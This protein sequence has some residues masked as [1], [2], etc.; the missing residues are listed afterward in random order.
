MIF[1]E[2]NN[3]IFFFSWTAILDILVSFCNKILDSPKLLRAKPSKKKKKK[4][5]ITYQISKTVSK[6]KKKKKLNVSNNFKL[7]C[8]IT[9]GWLFHWSWWKRLVRFKLLVTTD[10]EHLL[11][12]ASCCWPSR[13]LNPNH[14]QFIE[15]LFLFTDQ[16]LLSWALSLQL[17]SIL[18]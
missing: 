2:N 1:S 7:D 6:S 12:K 9:R 5:L 11:Q 16:L 14:L 3:S 15:P 18:N 13:T 10:F 4:L 8:A 17:D